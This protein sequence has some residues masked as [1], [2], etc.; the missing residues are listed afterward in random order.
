MNIGLNSL[1]KKQY[2]L[3]AVALALAGCAG[4]PAVPGSCHVEQGDGGATITC[5]DGSEAQLS[6]GASGPAGAQRNR[7]TFLR[8]S[9]TAFSG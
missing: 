3:L 7:S 1:V 2:P 9:E 5:S 4:E 8:I 6:D